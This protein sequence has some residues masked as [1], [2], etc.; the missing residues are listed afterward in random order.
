MTRAC[1]IAAENEVGVV[2]SEQVKC[3][4]QDYVTVAVW[5][6]PTRVLHWLNALTI[7]TLVVFGLS[8]EGVSELAFDDEVKDDLKHVLMRIHSYA[9]YFLAVTYTCRVIWGFAGNR[10]AR[11]SDM[12]S[13]KKEHWAAIGAN[14]KWYHSG[15]RGHP[16]VSTGHNPL[17]S[18]FYLPLFL[19]LGV[20]VLTG[21]TLAGLEY[22]VFPGTLIRGIWGVEGVS[23]MG[24]AAEEIHEVGFYFILFF[25]CC[26]MAGLVM[27]EIGERS[28]LLSAMI[29]GRKYFPRGSMEKE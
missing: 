28:G 12:I 27:H 8:M 11:F 2:A 14:I 18:L 19:V 13:F 29:H 5:D 15:F 26:H 16:P 17:A 21:V 10:H 22:D 4:A 25:F 1:N 7:I 23:V 3:E 20:M 24:D 6:V 9:G